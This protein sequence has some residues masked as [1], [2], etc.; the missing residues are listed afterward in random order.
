MASAVWLFYG[1]LIAQPLVSAETKKADARGQG[2]AETGR[3]IFNGKG[4]C[5]YCHGVDGYLDKPPQLAPDTAAL[6]AQLNPPPADLRNSKTLRLKSD[7]ARAKAIRDGHPGTGMFPTTT[8][9][10]QELT[11]TL[12]YLA[13]LRKEGH[14]QSR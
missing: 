8:L 5:H 9:T 7:K 6:I 12:S 14:P 3:S 11:G 1:L 2:S 10:R 13:S 4:V